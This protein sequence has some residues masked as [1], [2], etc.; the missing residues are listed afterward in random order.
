MRSQPKPFALV[1]V[2]MVGIRVV[3][4]RVGHR[5]VAVAVRVTSAWRYGF[6]VCMLMVLVVFVLVRM[7]ERFMAMLVLVALREMQPYSDRH[8]D[9]G[10]EELPGDRLS[11][12]HERYRCA[13][14]RSR[15]EVGARTCRTQVA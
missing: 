8:Q 15:R 10:D 13:D 12:E 9:G 14:E 4:M 6:F 11:Q 5:R 7:L 1:V 2:T 3:R